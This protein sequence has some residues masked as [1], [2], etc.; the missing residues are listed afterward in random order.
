MKVLNW[1]KQKWGQVP[2]QHER[3]IIVGAIGIAVL[4]AMYLFTSNNPAGRSGPAATHH[5]VFGTKDFETRFGSSRV[6]SEI[7]QIRQ[8]NRKLREQLEQ[9]LESQSSAA[10]DVPESK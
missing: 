4:G 9:M 8:E 6:G 5:K 1:F 7:E 3:W 2:A 10:G